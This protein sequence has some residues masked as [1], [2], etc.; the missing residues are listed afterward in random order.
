MPLASRRTCTVPNC[1]SGPLVEGED[2]PGPYIS[3]VECATRAEVS[4]DIRDH[5]RMAHEIPIQA[6][7][8]QITQYQAENE[9]LRLKILES[10]TT[11]ATGE[12][13]LEKEVKP[14]DE[15]KDT[16]PEDA[17]L[18][19]LSGSWFKLNGVQDPVRDGSIFEVSDV[20]TS[21]ASK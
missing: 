10:A 14:S 6:Q 15:Q 4:E 8:A 17:Q 16:S 5:V 11:E 2:E 1:K 3:H 20:F 21:E 9:R 7:Q 13:T 19:S 12:V 18:D